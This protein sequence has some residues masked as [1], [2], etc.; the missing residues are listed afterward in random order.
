M[1]CYDDGFEYCSVLNHQRDHCLMLAA[2]RRLSDH[3]SRRW[4]RWSFECNRHFIVTLKLLYH[5]LLAFLLSLPKGPGPLPLRL[6]IARKAPRFGII[7]GDR[8]CSLPLAILSLF[9]YYYCCKAENV[10]VWCAMLF[11]WIRAYYLNFLISFRLVS[12]NQTTSYKN[13]E[14]LCKLGACLGQ[15]GCCFVPLSLNHLGLVWVKV[16]ASFL[17]ARIT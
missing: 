7:Y 1:F 5:I 9:I 14:Q 4:H 13:C 11:V 2:H 17:S 6:R 8:W 12:V 15:T 10:S 3:W 16:S